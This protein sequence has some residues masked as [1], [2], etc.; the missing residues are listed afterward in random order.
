[1]TFSEDDEIINPGEVS[2]QFLLVKKGWSQGVVHI[3]YR[4]VAVLRNKAQDDR[5][6]VK[7]REFL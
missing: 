6:C 4:S 7:E 2:S 3:S 1:M 5:C